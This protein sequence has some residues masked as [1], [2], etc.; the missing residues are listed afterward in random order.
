[1]PDA[2]T[3]AR[4]KRVFFNEEV[5]KSDF[6]ASEEAKPFD[7]SDFDFAMTDEEPPI[8]VGSGPLSQADLADPSQPSA[9]APRASNKILGMT[10]A[11]LAILIAL[12]LALLCILAGFAYIIST[13][14]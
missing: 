7:P 13:T 12:G 6:D 5:R 1:M 8:E 14:S 11:Q 10:P 4:E 3:K 2:A 9:R